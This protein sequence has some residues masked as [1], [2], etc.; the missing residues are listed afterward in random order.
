M[1]YL[2]LPTQSADEANIR[3]IFTEPGIKL[4]VRTYGLN[5]KEVPL[6][7]LHGLQSHSGWFTQSSSY[8]RGLGYPVYAFDRFG[9][10][11]SDKP[12]ASK[13]FAESFLSSLDAVIKEAMAR[14]NHSQVHL[15]GHCLGALFASFY[16]CQRSKIIRSLLLATPGVFTKT[17]LRI[18]DKLKIFF[19]AISGMNSDVSVGLKPEDFSELQEF[20]DFIRGDKLSLYKAPSGF[21]WGI[22]IM[23]KL[24]NKR[25]NHLT[26]PVF[27]ASAVD[28]PICDNS[29]NKQF[30]DKIP[31]K[32]KTCKTYSQARHILEFSS[33]R[34]VF[35]E[36]LRSWFSDIDRV[37]HA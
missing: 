25:I 18:V 21:F 19:C 7:L 26:M 20:I 35:F 3:H 16:A 31:S 30:F 36:D 5:S 4:A 27:M 33:Q 13:D 14:H 1:D 28:D 34:D 29:K 15:L 8:I 12:K 37:R 11:L 22:H 24:V 32:V 23:R 9:S 6:I 2:T 17:D 10:G